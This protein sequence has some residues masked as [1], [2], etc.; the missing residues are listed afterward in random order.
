VDHARQRAD[1]K[2]APEFHPWVELLPRPAVHPDLAAFASLAVAN[3]DRAARAVQVALLERECLADPKPSAPKQHDQGAE[4]VAVSAVA[5]GSHHRDDLLDRRRIGRVL[6]A[7]VSRRA[8]SV[9]AGYG[10]RGAT[11]AGDIQQDGLHDF[12]PGGQ[13]A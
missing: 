9:I 4:P 3:E 13:V 5:N 7:L 11:M 1:R 10:R 8:A 2:F 12:L 6:L